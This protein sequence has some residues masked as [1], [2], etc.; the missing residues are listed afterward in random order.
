MTKAH[1]RLM[2]LPAHLQTFRRSHGT[3]IPMSATLPFST[4]LSK[5]NTK[6]HRALINHHARNVRHP[7]SNNAVSNGRPSGRLALHVRLAPFGPVIR[8]TMSVL[9][10]KAAFRVAR[11]DF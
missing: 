5:R 4:S 10:G 6:L 1:G 9:E 7:V 2:S 11:P 8:L 3:S